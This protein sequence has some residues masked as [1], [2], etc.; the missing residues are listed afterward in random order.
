[1][2]QNK[3]IRTMIIGKGCSCQASA[4]TYQDTFL[5]LRISLVDQ[6]ANVFVLP[7]FDLRPFVRRLTIGSF[8]TSGRMSALNAVTKSLKR[9][10]QIYDP[11]VIRL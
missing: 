5:S 1:M 8:S 4:N 7:V 11:S 3:S 6:V 2:Q 10:K 9:T